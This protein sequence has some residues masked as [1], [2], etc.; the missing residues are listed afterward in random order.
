MNF[1]LGSMLP[2]N[3]QNRKRKI[4]K[5]RRNC[6]ENNFKQLFRFNRENVTFLANHF[7]KENNETRGGALSNVEKMK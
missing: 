3:G 1:L 4:Y 6:D 2:V 7:L 5:E